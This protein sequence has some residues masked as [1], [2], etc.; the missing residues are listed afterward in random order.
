MRARYRVL[1]YELG[2]AEPAV[3]MDATGEGF[4]AAVGTFLPGEQMAGQVGRGGPGD[5]IAHIALYV[6]EEL[7]GGHSH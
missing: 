2:A 4:V 1:V 6:A 7:P 5:L 3:V